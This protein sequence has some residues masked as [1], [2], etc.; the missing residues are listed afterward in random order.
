MAIQND[1]VTYPYTAYVA[2]R[3]S[4]PAS[5]VCF[6]N[7]QQQRAL[8]YWEPTE[9][10][11]YVSLNEAAKALR[12]GIQGFVDRVTEPMEEVAQFVSAGEDSRAL[13]GLLPKRL[14]RDAYIFL[15][16]MNREGEIAQRVAGIY[17]ANFTP[18]FRTKTHYLDILPEASRLVGTG[19]Q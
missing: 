6:E 8:T 10:N 16:Y 7:N 5:I 12:D 1:V 2:I 19:H 9:H 4:P 15:D 11:P 3:Q 18:G 17:D 13:S 14:K